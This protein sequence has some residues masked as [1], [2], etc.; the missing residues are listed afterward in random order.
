MS[1]ADLLAAIDADP[2]DDAP[3]LAHAAW[4]EANADPER[5]RFIRNQIAGE[6]ANPAPWLAGLPSVP[7]MAWQCRRGYPEAVTFQSLAAFKKG[8]PLAAT[9]RVRHVVFSCLRAAKLADEPALASIP[10]LDFT[11]VAPAIILAVLRSPRLGPLR[12]LAVR[13]W[14]ADP[15]FLLALAACPAGPGRPAL[16]AHQPLRLVAVARGT[17]RRPGRVAPSGRAA[18]PPP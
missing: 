2:D 13:P 5:A 15:G 1:E 3:R 18:L 12:H 10:S 8:W 9:H 16:A 7:G 11:E 14:Q 6:W 17:P 4:L